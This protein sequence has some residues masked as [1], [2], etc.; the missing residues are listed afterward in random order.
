MEIKLL[1]IENKVQLSITTKVSSLTPSLA[2][3]PKMTDLLDG[4]TTRS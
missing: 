4:L 3:T 2:T 1:T